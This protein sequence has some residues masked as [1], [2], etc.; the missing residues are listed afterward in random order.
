M[1]LILMIC[2]PAGNFL[3]LKFEVLFVGSFRHAAWKCVTYLGCW[4]TGKATHWQGPRGVGAQVRVELDGRPSRPFL[5]SQSLLLLG[6][7]WSGVSGCGGHTRERWR[8]LTPVPQLALCGGC[9]QRHSCPPT[10]PQR[11]R[12]LASH[13]PAVSV[14]VQKTVSR[15]A[16][17]LTPPPFHLSCNFSSVYLVPSFLVLTSLP[18][19]IPLSF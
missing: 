13:S 8:P 9:R 2:E 10:L 16:D 3:G 18:L 1:M 4:G 6:A 12:Q 5:R 11:R 19:R 14:P 7:R 15:M 17:F